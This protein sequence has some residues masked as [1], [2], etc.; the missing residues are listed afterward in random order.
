MLNKIKKPIRTPSNNNICHAHFNSLY[1]ES[2]GTIKTCGAKQHSL[3]KYPDI[4]INEAWEGEKINELRQEFENGLFPD[5]CYVCK[6][7]IKEGAYES[8][9]LKFHITEELSGYPQILAFECS[10]KCNLQCVMCYN[11]DNRPNKI[12]LNNQSIEIY[13]DYFIKELIPFIPHVKAARFYGGEP[14][15]I[16]LYYK[17]WDEFIR[18]N[19]D[20]QIQIS[21]NG[22]ILNDKIKKILNRGNFNIIISIDSINKKNYEKI[23]INSDLNLVLSN[24]EYFLNYC[25]SKNKE[26]YLVA[27]YMQQNWQDIPDLIKFCNKKQINI[28]INRIWLPENSVLYNSNS[29][30]LNKIISF[31]K[32]I[33]L[34]N[35]ST[36]EKN[37]YNRF[38]ETLNQ[39]IIWKNELVKK[40]NEA[41]KYETY[42][43]K[44]LFEDLEISLKNYNTKNKKEISY[45]NVLG[46]INDLLNQAETENK[47][48]TILLYYLKLP[49]EMTY[50]VYKSGCY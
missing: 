30:L 41:S 32:T 2:D 28:T 1:F 19:P 6:T 37:N 10:N 38:M 49:P 7:Q 14:F 17:I 31:Y 24:L 50:S 27:C 44:E 47:K 13:N 46:F 33:N 18:I 45:M 26:L 3:G 39:T 34:E 48:R 20:C 40:E 22:T 15:L 29:D 16:P 35:N 5:S 25:H 23:R 43:I 36:I 21:T 11:N 8:S 9:F 12:K 42:S 4:S